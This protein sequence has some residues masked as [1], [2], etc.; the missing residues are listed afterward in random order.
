M[1][2]ESYNHTTVRPFKGD[3]LMHDE[4]YDGIYCGN[5]TSLITLRHDEYYDGIYCGNP[6]SLITLRHDELKL[7]L[8]QLRSR[9]FC[10]V[11]R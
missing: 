10:I 4:Y 8:E 11:H 3:E 6:T 2:Y 7:F 1:S 5:P 9:V